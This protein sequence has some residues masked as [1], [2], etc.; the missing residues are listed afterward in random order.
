MDK[1]CTQL[2]KNTENHAFSTFLQ[3]LTQFLTT[4]ENDL[5]LRVP[6]WFQFRSIPI[7]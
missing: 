2:W 3:P 4:H 1:D 5:Y 7:K 6:I